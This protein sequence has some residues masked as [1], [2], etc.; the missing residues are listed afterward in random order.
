MLSVQVLHHQFRRGSTSMMILM[1]EMCGG[2][3]R[4]EEK[5][6]IYRYC[7]ALFE[8]QEVSGSLDGST[9]SELPETDLLLLYREVSSYFTQKGNT[10]FN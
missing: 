2:G 5:L 9:L 1:M 10:V 8:P 6:M 4:I 7:I 3:S